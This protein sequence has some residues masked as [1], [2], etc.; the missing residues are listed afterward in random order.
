MAF[1]TVDARNTSSETSNTTSHTVSLPAS[2]QAD[3]LLIVVFVAD[4]STTVSWPGSWV[5]IFHSAGSVTLDVGWLKAAGGETSIAVTTGGSENSAHSSLRISGGGD[6]ASTSPT[7]SSGATGTDAAP[8]PDSHTPG[9]TQDFLWIAAAGHDDGRDAITTE[10]SG[11]ANLNVIQSSAATGC[12]V[13]TAEL[14]SAAATEDP[15]V[16]TLDNTEQW[17]ACTIAVF[18]VP[19]EA[20]PRDRVFIIS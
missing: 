17:A 15:D 2:V 4:G 10:P 5:S 1:A 6:P 16:F 14:D 19:P 7:T 20:P 13:G 8:D 3:D 9:G 18:P 11:Y 12:G